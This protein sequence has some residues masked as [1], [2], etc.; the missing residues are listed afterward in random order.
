LCI[1]SLEAL[2]AS[3]CLLVWWGSKSF[4]P[5]LGILVSSPLLKSLAEKSRGS[6]Q[7]RDSDQSETYVK[8]RRKRKSCVSSD[9]SMSPTS[10]PRGITSSSASAMADSRLPDVIREL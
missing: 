8:F 7:V 9:R 4:S 1:A 6:R 2:R 3:D 5:L 10:G